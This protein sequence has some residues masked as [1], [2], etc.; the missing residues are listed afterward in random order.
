MQLDLSDEWRVWD[1]CEPLTIVRPAPDGDL[2]DYLPLDTNGAGPHRCAVKRKEQA[3]S[4]AVYTSLDADFLIPQALLAEGFR[5][6]P[7]YRLIDADQQTWTALDV[8]GESRDAT[9]PQV[10]RMSCRNFV[11]AYDLRDTITIERADI[12][13]DAA[14]VYVKTFPP[15]GGKALYQR[16]AARVQ[17]LT[18]EE[19]EERGIRAFKAAYAV[20]VA[21]QVPQLTPE[22]RI[23]W[24]SGG[25]TLYLQVAGL[26]NPERIDELPRINAYMPP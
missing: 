3:P 20:Y 21:Q 7:G 15:D 2:Q 10:W 14:G 17:L 13:T 24:T 22:D 25:V 19:A 26:E 8:A 11:L 23:Q 9:G 5:P 16:L 4:G 1:N 6:A 18:E 12:T